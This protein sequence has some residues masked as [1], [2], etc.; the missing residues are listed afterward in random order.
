M[1]YTEY[2]LQGLDDQGMLAD[3]WIHNPNVGSFFENEKC[4]Q[5]P[6]YPLSPKPTIS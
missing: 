4:S 3:L 1:G 6:V 5:S 2:I